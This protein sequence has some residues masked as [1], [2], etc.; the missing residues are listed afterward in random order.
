MM[1][2]YFH[3]SHFTLHV[4]AWEMLP[5][6]LLTGAGMAFTFSAM[7]AA[8]MRTVPSPMLTAASSLYT[9]SRRIGGNL[10]YA[11]VANQILHRA[12]FHQARLGEHLTP[13]DTTT[14]Q[15]VDGLTGQLA[16]R[17]LPPGVAEDSVLK[18]LG[19]TVQRQA[20]MMAYNDVFWMMGMCFVF[21]LPFLLLLGRH[22]RSPVP[23]SAASQHA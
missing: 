3:M 17:G 19:G 20:T 7:S 23:V 4:G 11:F 12:A 8:V 10:G 22:R 1:G 13:Y 15:I 6:L 16:S 14:T 21:C 5:G 18:L 9:L 2:G